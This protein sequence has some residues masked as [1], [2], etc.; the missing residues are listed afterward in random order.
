ME[1]TARPDKPSQQNINAF[2]TLISF[3]HAALN[4]APVKPCLRRIARVER[5]PFERLQEMHAA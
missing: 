1:D 2:C 3:L 5:D 4:G